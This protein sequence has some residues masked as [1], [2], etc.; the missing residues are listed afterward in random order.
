MAGRGAE[1]LLSCSLRMALLTGER[2]GSGLAPSLALR[3]VTHPRGAAHRPP[4]TSGHTHHMTVRAG[5]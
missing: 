4:H 3:T 1:L 2:P 5:A